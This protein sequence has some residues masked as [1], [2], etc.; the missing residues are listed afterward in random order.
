MDED[1]KFGFYRAK[2]VDN[3][4][5]EKYGRVKLW[6]P[7]TMPE[8]EDSKGI[9]AFSANNPASG[10]NSDGESKFY[11][12]S[13]I[14]LKDSWV[15]CFFEQGNPNRPFYFCGLDISAVKVLPEC[16]L[17]SN[18]EQK[19]V[20][21]KSKD[22]K[23]IIISD[24]PDDARVEITGKKRNLSNPPEGDTGSVYTI[25]GNQTT[26]LLDERSGKEKILIKTHQGDFLNIDV[27]GRKLDARFQNDINI[28]SNQSINIQ[29]TNNI[30]IKAG[31]NLN[32]SA[33]SN[34]SLKASANLNA[35]AGGNMNNL[36]SGVLKDQG[37]T[38]THN[39][40]AGPAN[41]TDP[42]NP[43]GDR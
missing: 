19:W 40:G 11:G 27:T 15:F 16:Q 8:I 28:K 17:G 24:D 13:Y 21:F 2:V 41:D 32:A 34:L 20:I 37:S 22:G 5:P 14:P 38:I 3:K 12:S 1:K 42:A 18:Y 36:A 31:A 39:S 6:I 43:K 35:Q 26:I 4:D 23:C 25:D 7:D 29:A 33:A 10:R 30:N 9:W